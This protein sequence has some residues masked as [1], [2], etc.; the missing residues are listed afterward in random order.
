M[1]M[2]TQKQALELIKPECKMHDTIES[3]IAT[4]GGSGNATF[5]QNS[6][7]ILIYRSAFSLYYKDAS[8][9][10]SVAIIE[11]NNNR[12]LYKAQITLTKD[13]TAYNPIDVFLW[14]SMN[15][16]NLNG[17]YW[18]VRSYDNFK[19]TVTQTLIGT[20]IA[21]PVPITWTFGIQYYELRNNPFST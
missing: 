21:N 10:K 5:A 3:T 6:Y 17:F 11:S 20:T 7:D 12:D 9:N 1:E 18:L 13:K 15:E 8:T 2:L 16:E 4:S 19:V 14:N